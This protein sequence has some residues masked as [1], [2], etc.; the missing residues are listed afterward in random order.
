MRWRRW[1][2]VLPGIVALAIVS[3]AAPG[4]RAWVWDLPAG[5][6]APKVPADNP[7]TAEKVEL[8]RHL[9]Y[10]TRL[11]LT[12]TFSCASCH[13]QE[14]AFADPLP[15]GVGAT[16]EVHP[17]GSMSLANVVYTPAL[18][19]VNPNL[20]TLEAQALIP[21]F[22]EHP[23]ELGLAGREDSILR[24]LS[25]DSRYRRMFPAAFANESQPLSVQNI[26]RAIAT[27]QRTLLSGRSPYDRFLQGD[28]TAISTL[29][30]RGANLFFSERLECFHCHG[31]FSFSGSVDHVNLPFPEVEFHNTGLYNIGGN[32]GFPRENPGLK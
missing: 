16:G 12:G 27:F 29:A 22:G 26:T 6:P 13:Q 11:S 3:A 17:R 32:G 30:K 1:A 25:V 21:M 23:I 14:R 20:R 9:F 4:A 5:F 8:G 2:L 31:G 10:D 7:M 28:T 19:W 15:R 24:T 18:T